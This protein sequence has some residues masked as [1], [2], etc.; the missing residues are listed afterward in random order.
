MPVEIKL[1]RKGLALVQ[2]FYFISLFYHF[3]EFFGGGGWI[4]P[5]LWKHK[6]LLF[7]ISDGMWLRWGSVFIIG[8]LLVYM[9][10]GKLN[11]LGLVLLYFLNMSFYLWN[12][13]IIHEPQPITN[14]FFLSF[15]LLPLKEEDSY[16]SWI[17]N[18]LI[19]FLGLYYFLAGIK[20]LPDPHFLTG[21]ALENII[22]WPVMAKDLSLNLFL[23]KYFK[24]PVRIFNYLTLLFEIS[25]IFL[26]YTRARVLLI[27]FG[28]LLHL[29][30][31]ATLEVGNFSWVMMVWYLLLLDKETIESFSKLKTNV[32]NIKREI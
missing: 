9:F 21:D 19:I 25:F 23:V 12:P 17:K 27:V 32:F 18:S 20:K 13:L 16:D 11:R 10:L 30:I 1:F 28:V 3:E 31:Y 14:L 5:A 15:F 7:L 26:I 4:A 24:Y 8:I 2:G 22:S 6:Y 29:L